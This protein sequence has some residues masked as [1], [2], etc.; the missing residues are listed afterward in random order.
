MAGALSSSSISSRRARMTDR[1]RL[2]ATVYSHGLSAA[3]SW[4]ARKRAIG[5]QE[6][7]LHDVLGLLARAEHV[8]AER[9][10]LAVVRVVER[11]ERRVIPSARGG[12]QGSLGPPAQGPPARGLPPATWPAP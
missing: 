10:Q 1:Q 5:G 6:R 7:V 2:R 4:P 9:Q 11:L 3:I 12:D 8:L